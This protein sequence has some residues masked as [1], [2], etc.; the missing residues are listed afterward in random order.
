MSSLMGDRGDEPRL[1][2]RSGERVTSEGKLTYGAEYRLTDRWSL[3]AEY[4]R[5]GQ[6]NAGARWRAL[7]K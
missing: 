1:S 5:W 6:V 7:E 4:D 2:F 3:T